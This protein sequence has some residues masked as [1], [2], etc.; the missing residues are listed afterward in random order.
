MVTEAQ[1][2][3]PQSKQ[4][5]QHIK[6]LL[7]SLL[8]LILINILSGYLFTRFDLTADKRY[9]L[10]N[11]TKD[12]IKEVDDVVYFEIYLDGK[13]PASF[14]RLK[15]SIKELLD[16][17]RVYGKD[18]I[19]YQFTDPISNIDKSKRTNVFKRLY[20]K[21][22]M[23]I[24]LQVKEKDGSS[25][26]KI[27]FPGIIVSYKGKDFP[28]NLLKNKNNMLSEESLN[29]AV[30]SLEYE[31]SFAIDN[32]LNTEKKKIAILQ[33]HGELQPEQ[34]EDFAQ[35]LTSSFTVQVLNINDDRYALSD[36]NNQNKYELLIIAKPTKEFS[37]KDKF[38]IDQFIMNG[39]KTLWLIDPVHIEMDSLTKGATTLAISRDLNLNDQLFT[40][41]VRVNSN[42]IQ[43]MQCLLI[44]INTAI[45]GAPPKFTSAPWV[46]CPLLLPSDANPITRNLNVISSEFP[47]VIDTVGLNS[48]VKKQFLLASSDHSRIVKT[49][50]QIDLR[51][52]SQQMNPRAFNKRF[53][54]VAVLLQGTFK[55]VY[56][57]RKS[58]FSHKKVTTKAQA[59]KM[60]VVAD[61]DIIRNK[62][63]GTGANKK[64]LPLGYDRYS[65]Q[66][67]G[68]KE[69]LINTVNYLC[70]KEHLLRL[71]TKEQKLRLLDKVKTNKHKLKWQTINV[72]IPILLIVILGILLNVLRKRRFS[73]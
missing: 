56:H 26:Q 7:L 67:F 40:Y 8:A 59:T 9:T 25:S 17:F 11:N 21:G 60:V 49:P 69:F 47:A 33:G 71:R 38:V 55:S 23:P 62:V 15:K 30:Q 58:P 42:I 19:Q 72:I 14:I 48:D 73:K 70:D 66:T 10:S 20:K 68:N 34:V 32:L 28:I 37:E 1:N 61:G 6:H 3:N 57:N 43:D 35:S 46:F 41:G 27:L 12:L 4:K 53:L 24:N 16:E 36:A 50:T 64:I 13:M 31:L 39:G 52:A 5:T 63:I 22:L 44:P 51:I 45:A 54:P 2:K 29:Q 18:N 65:K